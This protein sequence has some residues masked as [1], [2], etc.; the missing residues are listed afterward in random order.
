MLWFVILSDVILRARREGVIWKMFDVNLFTVYFD[1]VPNP[2]LCQRMQ[3]M[4]QWSKSKRVS[5]Q[6]SILTHAD[7]CSLLRFVWAIKD[8]YCYQNFHVNCWTNSYLGGKQG[9]ST[10]KRLS[11]QTSILRYAIFF[12]LFWDSCGKRKVRIKWIWKN[13]LPNTQ[14][15]KSLV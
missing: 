7:P 5:C 13:I 9:L 1:A 12:C 2:D 11:C 8:N 14:E 4:R 6:T 3:G 15:C 10:S